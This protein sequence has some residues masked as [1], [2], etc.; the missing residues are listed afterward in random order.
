MGSIPDEESYFRK[1]DYQVFQTF[2]QKACGI[3]L[4]D[5][6]Q[7]LVSNRVRTILQELRIDTLAQLVDLIERGTIRGLKER[8]ID[9]MTTNE[10]FWFRDGFPFEAL[11]QII[12][13]KLL[14]EERKPGLRIWSAACSSGQ[15]PYS[16]SMIIEEFKAAHPAVL[17]SEAVIMATDISS[18]VLNLARD[19]VYDKLTI[20]RGL[21][22]QRRSI[23]FEECAAGLFRLRSSVVK[24]VDFRTLN[25]LDN[26][27]ALGSFD[28]IFCR[29]VLIYFSAELK[30]D[31]LR[32]MSKSLAPG[33]ILILGASESMPAA[34]GDTYESERIGGGATVYR[35]RR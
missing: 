5:H 22:A 25:L 32:R 23:F 24:R 12:L 6:K 34:M 7:Y 15:E 10:T 11:Q 35:V 9:A 27:A 26:F 16:I 31:I 1:D 21:S 33:G 8:V 19:A 28:I 2:L 13:P 4:G 18:K 29:N 30:C 17:R 3:V 14:I 20:N